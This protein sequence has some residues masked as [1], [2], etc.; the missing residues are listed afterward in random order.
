MFVFLINI[1]A[2]KRVPPTSDV[3]LRVHRLV[4]AIT[5]SLFQYV[6]RGLFEQDRLVFTVQM[7]FQILIAS[8]DIDVAEVDFFL[9]FP[10]GVGSHI[11]I[12]PVDF[13]SPSAWGAVKGL[14]NIFF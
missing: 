1:R 4:D 12:S 9:R 5:Y 11:E 8:C 7:T 10:I 13:L 3:S 14:L 6:A 2:L